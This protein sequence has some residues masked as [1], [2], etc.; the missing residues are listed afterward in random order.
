MPKIERYTAKVRARGSSF[1]PQIRVQQDPVAGALD[2]FGRFLTGL[3][4]ELA[5]RQRR[6]DELE[7]TNVLLDARLEAHKRLIE[8]GPEM[9]ENP[10]GSIAR[11]KQIF[12]DVQAEFAERI[13][14]SASGFF[15]QR[16][17]QHQASVIPDIFAE[18]ADT[19]RE[20]RALRITRA[21]SSAGNTVSTDPLSRD[22]V[23]AEVEGLIDTSG[24]TPEAITA[25]KAELRSV[26]AQA[27]LARQIANDP[28][29][30]VDGLMDGRYDKDLT[31]KQKQTLLGQADR[32]AEQALRDRISAA[33]AAE[34]R[35][36]RQK[37]KAQ[38]EAYENLATQAFDD[39]NPLTDET[40]ETAQRERMITA[41]QA[42][43]LKQ[44]RRTEAEGETDPVVMLDFLEREHEGTLTVDRVIDAADGGHLS[45]EDANAFM[46]RLRQADRQG[47]TLAREDVRVSRQ[48]VR[49]IV[50][51][52]SGPAARFAGPDVQRMVD[53]DR[54]F[55]RL[56][57]EEKLPPL[58]AERR[59]TEFYRSNPALLPKPMFGARPT[60][61]E[62]VRRIAAE[63]L[64]A[65]RANVISERDL[66]E[67]TELLERY[68][69]SFNQ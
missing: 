61:P 42:T 27:E 51:G 49:E 10:A 8:A 3:G 38:D 21:I 44:I 22:Q 66:E 47:G 39:G 16:W 33:E 62:D 13:P 41:Q 48:R 37:K 25:K 65:R 4:D 56:V 14:S 26:L 52:Q 57:T 67:Q 68:M 43:K 34:R 32:E 53:A 29:R 60:R 64:R 35:A 46:G 11:S 9:A 7:T 12:D 20:Q 2:D 23:Q 17:L 1:V 15:Q 30:A 58:E 28:E 19:Q 6:D 69:E 50:G 55:L 45:R 24:L 18:A 63:T 54:A 36:E 59:V 40:I 31:F 5:D